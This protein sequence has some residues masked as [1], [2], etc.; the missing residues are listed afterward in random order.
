MAREKYNKTKKDSIYWYKDNEGKKKYA[1]RYKFY[2]QHGKRSEKS[3]R[4]FNS[5]EECERAL[6][7]VKA[8]VLNGNITQLDKMQITLS[9]WFSI[10]LELKKKKIKVS[11]YSQ[12]ESFFRL[13]LNPLIGHHKLKH[14]TKMVVQHDL[15]DEMIDRGLSEKT[16]RN[17]V[18]TL[19]SS[20]IAAVE[21]EFL[22]RRRFTSLDYRGA[23]PIRKMDTL[24]EEELKQLIILAKTT[25]NISQYTILLTIAQTGMRKGESLALCW[26]DIDFENNQISISRTRD[27]QSTRS[28]KTKNSIRTIDMNDELA[29]VLRRYRSWCIEIKLTH[30]YKLKESDYVFISRS[31]EPVCD[32]YP[33]WALNKI[34]EKHNFREITIHTLRHTVASILVGNG[35]PVPTVAKILGDTINVVNEVYSHSLERKE[36]EAIEILG[37]IANLK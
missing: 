19:N 11:T 31:G 21:E 18:T 6:I 29:K 33:N 35:V 37:N 22:D 10:W 28:A 13:Y 8:T 30:G 34:I 25:C 15:V 24:T 9:E 2:D 17:T 20:L 3:S 12:Y 7:E 14:L 5:I 16:I 32:H 27:Y 26:K 23:K 36:K 1:Y 4:N